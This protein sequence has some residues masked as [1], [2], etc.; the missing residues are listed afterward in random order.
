[1]AFKDLS[2]VVDIIHQSVKLYSCLNY[3]YVYCVFPK[4]KLAYY[5]LNQILMNKI[6]LNTSQNHYNP[7]Q[8]YEPFTKIT[9]KN[10]LLLP[11]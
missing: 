10:S 5:N 11:F 4:T 1:M 2:T 8:R 3:T 9:N 6:H 7:G